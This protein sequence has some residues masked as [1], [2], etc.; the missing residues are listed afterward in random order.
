M[1]DLDKLAV[2]YQ[3]RY[4]NIYHGPDDVRYNPREMRI[5]P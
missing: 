4:V 5:F 1:Y 3:G 2:L